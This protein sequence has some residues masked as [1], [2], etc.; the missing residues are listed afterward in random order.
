MIPFDLLLLVTALALGLSAAALGTA[1]RVGAVQALA[2]LLGANALLVVRGLAWSLPALGWLQGRS[3]AVVA[4]SLFVLSP[5]LLALAVRRAA[6]HGPL[7]KTD[8]QVGIPALVVLA[9]LGAKAALRPDAPVLDTMEAAVYLVG[10]NAVAVTA[11]V[12]TWRALP[13]LPDA[14]RKGGRAVV[15]AFGVHWGWSTAAWTAGL[16]DWPRG[17]GAACEALSVGT[18]LAFG[19]GAAWLGLR[20]LPAALPVPPPPPDPHA[21]DADRRLAHRV[22]DI[23]VVD[24]RYLN[25]DLTVD[26]LAAELREPTRDVSRVLN[27]RLGGGFHEA[28]RALRVTEAQRLLLDQPNATVLDVLF[29]SGFNSKSAFHRAFRQQTGTTP[30][31]FR[32]APD[33]SPPPLAAQKDGAGGV[34]LPV[35]G[36]HGG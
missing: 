32:K 10:L 20:R 31:A 30:G 15:L 3:A 35:L 19:L 11:Y 23:L 17:V 1:G 13:S 21:E 26:A 25:P 4:L 12:A 28:V 6:T 2:L 5:P 18:L 24:R 33:A 29:R 14:V 36:R 22:H 8:L 9:V 27:A 7:R 34:P 16:L